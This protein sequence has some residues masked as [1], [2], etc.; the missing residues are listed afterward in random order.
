MK[1]SLKITAA[2]VVACAVP[3]ALAHHS[4]GNYMMTE[5]IRLEGTVT[6]IHWINPHSWIYM[7]VTDEDGESSL[8]SLE[9]ASVNELRMKG[10]AADSIEPG[11]TIA[12]RCHQLRDRSNG[13]L[14][15]Y[16][17]AAGGEERLFD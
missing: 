15:G 14:L 17:T 3:A 12:V 16:V 9:G 11:D 2:V 10:W 4:H 5:Y 8:W 7:E 13:C 6:E 1:R